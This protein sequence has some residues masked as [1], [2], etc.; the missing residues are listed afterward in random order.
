MLLLWARLVLRKRLIKL[1]VC[2]LMKPKRQKEQIK[3]VQKY[4]IQLIGDGPYDRDHLARFGCVVG[5]RS[6]GWR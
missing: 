2:E 6:G 3:S 1:C 5:F 4:N